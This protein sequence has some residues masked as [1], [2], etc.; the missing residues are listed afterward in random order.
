MR[1]PTR[2]QFVSSIVVVALLALGFG[3]W[4]HLSHRETM[5]DEELPR[6]P[7]PPRLADGP[8]ARRCMALLRDDPQGARGYALAWEARGG[9]EGAQYCDGLAILAL[10]E[11]LR[12]AERLEAIASRSSAGRTAR[13][14]V[15]AQAG[16][17]WLMA[18]DSD[19]AFAAATLALTLTP[20]DGDLLIDRAVRNPGRRN[21]PAAPAR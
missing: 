4:S 2:T 3:V 16:Q 7:D 1:R 6:P 5:T 15:F 13:A 20:E 11:P 8:E 21:A 19:R 12:A 17:A 14:A 18:G 10:G 9:G